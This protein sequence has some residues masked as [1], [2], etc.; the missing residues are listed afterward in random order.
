MRFSAPL[1]GFRPQSGTAISVYFEPHDTVSNS[2]TNYVFASVLSRAL[3]FERYYRAIGTTFALHGSDLRECLRQARCPKA[4][5]AP[6]S[7]ER[8]LG[9]CSYVTQNP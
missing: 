7:I 5:S 9:L 4:Y 3:Y 1:T 2:V 8:T 6:V